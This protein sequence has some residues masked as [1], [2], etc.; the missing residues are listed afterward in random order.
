MHRDDLLAVRRLFGDVALIPDMQATAEFRARHADGS[1]RTVEV[2]AKNLLKDPAINGIVVNYRDVTERR[3]LEQQLRH[4]AFHDALTGLPNRALFLDRLSHS[5]ARTRRGHEPL[6]VVFIDLDDFKAVND[7]FG[8]VAGDE[9]LV[10]VAGRIRMSVRES[11]TPARMGGDE[12]AILLEDAP[13]VEAAR[14]SA[15]RILEALRLPFRLQEQD[16]AIRASAGIAMYAS[17][18]QSADELLRNADVVDVLRE[19]AGQ[20][21]ARGLRVGGPR[22]RDLAPAAPDGPPAGARAPGVRAG[23]PARRRPRDE[24]DHGRRSAAPVVAPAPR[25]RRPDRVHPDRRGD[26]A[27]RADR[28][29]GARAGVPPGPCLARGT[30]A[31]AAST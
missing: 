27:D 20:G 22:C 9:L 10:A 8:H 3:S 18:E 7:S 30:A 11:D 12:F 19:G 6:A 31:V 28:A 17:P 16:V 25:P 29:L 21:P 15:N 4:Q 13:T 23:L 5:L 1:W 26:G 24:R 2:V 14:E